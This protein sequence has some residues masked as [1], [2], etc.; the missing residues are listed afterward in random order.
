MSQT[1]NHPQPL[2]CLAWAEGGHLVATAGTGMV[3]YVYKMGSV[4]EERIHEFRGHLSCVVSCQF[5]SD[6]TTLVTASL[7]T[8]INL[9]DCLNGQL[10]QTFCHAFPVPQFIFGQ[11]QVR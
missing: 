4:I 11:N 1:K 2:H 3:V 7:D 8:R 10:R 9:W 5:S 6:D